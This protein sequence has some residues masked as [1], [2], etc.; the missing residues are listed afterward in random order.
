MD[1]FATDLHIDEGW[2]RRSKDRHNKRVRDILEVTVK[3]MGPDDTLIIGGDIVH[4]VTERSLKE[5]RDLIKDLKCKKKICPGNHD[6]GM[7]GTWHRRNKYLKFHNEFVAPVEGTKEPRGGWE[8]RYPHFW[9]SNRRLNILLDSAGEVR[10]LKWHLARGHI[11][12][13]QLLVLESKL[14]MW[15]KA[16]P[17]RAFM[18]HHLLERPGMGLEMHD[19]VR[20]RSALTAFSHTDIVAYMGHKHERNTYNW[21][22]MKM[23]ATG[24]FVDAGPILVE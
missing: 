15:P 11:G 3:D 1:K 19:A 24:K 9:V 20:C 2:G 23:E 6:A 13:R 8:R 5:A 17:V 16:Y 22:K 18:H 7:W 21:P 14:S 10:A 12:T 4:N